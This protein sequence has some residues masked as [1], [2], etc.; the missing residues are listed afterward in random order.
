PLAALEAEAVLDVHRAA[1]VVGQLIRGVLPQPQVLLLDAQVDVPGLAVVDPVL[2]PLRV[3][4]RLDEELHLHLLELPRAE[5]E[6]ARRDLVAEGLADLADAVRRL[7][8]R[9]R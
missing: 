7:I 3:G 8:T 4:P 2:V 5:D 6:V 1:G 9:R